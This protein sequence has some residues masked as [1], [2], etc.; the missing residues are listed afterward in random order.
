[1]LEGIDHVISGRWKNGFALIR[2]PGHHHSNGRMTINGFCILNN[3]AIGARYIQK[4]Y[5]MK[6]I[7]IIDYDI[8][9]GDGTHYIF[10]EDP[11]VL[12]I[13]VHRHDHGTYYPAGDVG[14]Y[15]NCGSG[16]GEGS[17]LNIPL[18]YLTK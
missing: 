17:C 5:G 8:H 6:K 18:N 11:D 13:S 12:F 10:R 9:Q 2:P 7:A 15:L 14:S 3:I 1:M 16:S 4:K